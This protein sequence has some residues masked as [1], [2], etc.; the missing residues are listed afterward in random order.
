MDTHGKEVFFHSGCRVC[1][2]SRLELSSRV[3]PDTSQVG[4]S[5]M[6][7]SAVRPLAL[8]GLP[9]RKACLCQQRMHRPAAQGTRCLSHCTGDL[10]D[11]DFF[12]GGGGQ[13]VGVLCT[14]TCSCAV[15]NLSLVIYS[16]C[17][18][19][20]MLGRNI[21]GLG[22][23]PFTLSSPVCDACAIGQRAQLQG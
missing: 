5:R 8:A 14:L 7:S 9:A 22:T 2:G 20:K 12:W 4:R 11:A 13:T 1:S 23:K 19:L 21:A 16:P 6:R 3:C 15:L 18:L 17:P 10:S